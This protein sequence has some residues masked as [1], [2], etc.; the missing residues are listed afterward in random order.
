MK[1]ETEI[2]MKVQTKI[3]TE[4]VEDRDR[5]QVHALHVCCGSIVEDNGS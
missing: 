2:E 1:M 5:D 3:E 4:R